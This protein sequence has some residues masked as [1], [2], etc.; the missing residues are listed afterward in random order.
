[1]PGDKKQKEINKANI[2]DLYIEL[3]EHKTEF[4]KEISALKEVINNGLTAQTKENYELTKELKKG[5]NNLNTQ[6][7]MDAGKDAGK[8]EVWKNIKVYGAVFVAGIG[9]GLTI[10]KI[11]QFLGVI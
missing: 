1:M 9:A 5:F 10:L 4:R 3:E 7:M 8:K 2:Q 6:L 11:L